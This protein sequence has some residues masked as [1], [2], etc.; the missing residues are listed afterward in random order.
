MSDI[1]QPDRS[2]SLAA[3]EHRIYWELFGAGT[4]E[5]VCLLNGLAMHTGA[6]YGFLPRFRPEYDVLLWDYPGQ[7]R[8]STEDVPYRLDRIAAY[9]AC[10]LDDAG[11]DR[12]HVM[13]ISYGGFVALEFAR[14][15]HSRLHT[16]VL[17]GIILSH[18]TLFEMYENLSLR[19]Y[20]G[21]SDAFDLYTRY[22][23]E[24]IFGE[25]FVRA[26]GAE[27]LEAMRQNFHQR[28]HELT[29]ALTR[30]TEAQDPFF[31]ALDARMP[32]YRA[33]PTPTLVI[34][35]DEDR[36][37]APKVQKKI[38]TILPNSRFELIADSGH[39]VYLEQTDRFFE[40]ILGLMRRK[41]VW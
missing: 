16:L 12:I 13:G 11:I 33:I 25:A 5:V 15:F 3:D 37:M 14:Q 17:S 24:K 35:G 19:F 6:W 41:T 18:E 32:E 36:V 1:P 28:Y 38:T 4:R 7:G 30:L 2:G 39:V 40:L 20:R 26:A 31:A 9:L 27:R 21:G 8:S 23:Y 29:T 22:M 10:I 34:A